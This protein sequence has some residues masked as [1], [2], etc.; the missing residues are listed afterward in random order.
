M[1]ALQEYGMGAGASR[2]VTGNHPLYTQL[3]KELAEY[4]NT[5]DALVFGSGFLANLGVIT[6]LLP[7]DEMILADRL[8]HASLVD[9]IRL[10]GVKFQRFRHND[11]D[12]LR[13]LLAKQKQRCWIIT[14]SVF[15]MDG[16]RAPL[17]EMLNLA[18]EFD[19]MLVIDDAHGVGV[20]EHCLNGATKKIIW[21]G[22][23]S[24]AAGSYGGYVC[25]TRDHIAKMVNHSR[26][27]IYTTALPPA[28]IA[29]NL[30]ALRIIRTQPELTALPLEKAQLFNPEAQSAIVPIIIGEER[31]ALKAAEMLEEEGFLAI[32]IRPPTVPVGSSRLRLAFSALHE[33]KD[34]AR[35]A[36][37]IRKIRP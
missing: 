37:V 4:K 12:H 14:E 5:E 22:T 17:Q 18:E 19:A 29:A 35:L 15:S 2:L 7:P 33:A 28:V 23:F 27:L 26:S 11:S 9:A 31:E 25:A 20:V 10:S 34:I 6:A 21:I 36:A 8:I 3:E 24:K 1:A 13:Q 30:A 16:D 32:P